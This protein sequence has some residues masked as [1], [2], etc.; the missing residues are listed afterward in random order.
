MTAG[1]IY[2]IRFNHLCLLQKLYAAAS[3]RQPSAC[4][5]SRSCIKLGAADFSRCGDLCP[6]GRGGPQSCSFQAWRAS[7]SSSVDR[8]V[9]RARGVRGAPPHDI[10][11]TPHFRFLAALLHH[12]SLLNLRASIEP[13]NLHIGCVTG[14]V[15]QQHSTARWHPYHLGPPML[16]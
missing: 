1:D 2:H 13:P 5:L 7:D 12:L 4:H 3:C 14:L 6:S 15:R 9:N 11:P 16:R 10:F 8:R